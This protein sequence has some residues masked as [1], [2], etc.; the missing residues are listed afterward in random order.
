[1]RDAA[2]ELISR[3][4]IEQLRGWFADENCREYGQI[5]RHPSTE[6]YSFVISWYGGEGDIAFA[7]ITVDDKVLAAVHKAIE[8][9]NRTQLNSLITRI[10]SFAVFRAVSQDNGDTFLWRMTE[11]ATSTTY[12]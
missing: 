2:K 7:R 12:F 1:M 11:D 10:K 3:R 4:V 8:T 5:I 6:E 9:R